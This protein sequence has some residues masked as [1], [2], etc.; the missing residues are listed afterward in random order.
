MNG[1]TD[2]E[3]LDDDD[4]NIEEVPA[5]IS[6]QIEIEDES[7]DNAPVVSPPK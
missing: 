6:G 4:L 3:Q 7:D 5:E 1:G 2:E